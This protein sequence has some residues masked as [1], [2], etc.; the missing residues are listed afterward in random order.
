MDGADLA[1]LRRASYRRE[2]DTV[3]FSLV[4]YVLDKKHEMPVGDIAAWTRVVCEMAS[5]A[6]DLPPLADA[7]PD[8]ALCVTTGDPTSCEPR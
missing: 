7:A 4:G 5:K 1:R 8:G 6:Y 3:A 2:L